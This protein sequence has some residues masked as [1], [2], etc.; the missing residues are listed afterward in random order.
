MGAEAIEQTRQTPSPGDPEEIA[1]VQ[2][3]QAG[4]RP[5][6]ARLVERY[7]PR[8]YRWLFHLTHDRH[9][10]EDVA[11]ETFLKAMANLDRFRA[12]TNFRAW[13]FRIAHNAL[14]NLHRS[15]SRRRGP[16][17]EELPGR[18]P[19]PVERACTREALAEL[20]QAIEQL[21][22]DFRGA[23][24]LRVEEELSFRQ[25]A[26][27]LDITEETARWRVFK[28]RQKLLALLEEERGS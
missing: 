5:A 17:P 27:V 28:A 7:W 15:P 1:L 8:L 22:V 20:A 9:L 19:G 24:L 4:D 10:A 11:Q 25:I 6:F 23:L 18:D 14:A 16:L 2:A 13:L 21:P 12:G 3:A 26:G